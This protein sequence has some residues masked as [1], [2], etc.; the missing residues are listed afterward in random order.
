[1]QAGIRPKE[2]VGNGKPSGRRLAVA[3]EPLASDAGAPNRAGN[4]GR[5]RN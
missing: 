2:K 4:L 3:L 5:A 1:M